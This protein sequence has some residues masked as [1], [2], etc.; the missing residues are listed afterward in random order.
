MVVYLTGRNLQD[1]FLRMIQGRGRQPP[2]V[3]RMKSSNAASEHNMKAHW[4]AST[5]YVRLGIRTIEEKLR[6]ASGGNRRLEPRVVIQ[7]MIGRV[8]GW[9]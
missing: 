7:Q 9:L 1:I 4:I 8:S 6:S 3:H 5:R 2:S